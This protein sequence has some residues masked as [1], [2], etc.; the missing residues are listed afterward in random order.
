[1]SSNVPFLKSAYKDYAVY[2]NKNRA[3]PD[4]RDGLK[5]GQR[6]ALYLMRKRTGK[7]KTI[8]LAGSMIA[9]ELYVHGDK[10]AADSISQMAAPY[11]NNIPLLKGQGSFGSRLNPTAFASPRYTYVSKPAYLDQL[12]YADAEIIPMVEN[13]DGSKM[14]PDCFFPMVPT[15]ILNGVEGI[16]V[17]YRTRV[18][19]RNIND[20]INAISKCVRGQKSSLPVIE[21]CFEHLNGQRGTFNGYNANGGASWEFVGKVTIKDASTLLVTELPAV[22]ITAEKFKE[23]LN[24]MID[25]E[26]IKSTRDLS[27]NNIKIEIK[28]KRGQCRDWSENDA[29]DFLKLRKTAAENFVVTTFDG[30]GII[31]YTYD[32]DHKYPDPVERYIREWTDWRF[33]QYIN[34]YKNLLDLAQHELNYLLVVRACFRHNMA[35]RITKKKD[36]A[37]MRADIIDCAKKER[38]VASEDEANRVSSRASY[39]W[40]KEALN[41]VEDD[42]KDL[43]KNAKH[44]GAMIKSEDKRR[45]AFF[46]ELSTIKGLKI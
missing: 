8:A 11:L 12:L 7:I 31:N 2:V 21:P 30:T 14:V 13:H 18:F 15:H 6:V 22:G 40:T 27:S 3:I 34:R 35:D 28:L 19:P 45:D 41:K 26:L 9:E 4:A 32:K 33:G 46:D 43:L 42:I 36:R 29:I 44:Y 1:M 23:Q 37:D 16:G 38:L 5:Q 20:I 17:G 25:K 24:E 39:S 10:A